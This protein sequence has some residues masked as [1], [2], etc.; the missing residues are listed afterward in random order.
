MLGEIKY[1]IRSIPPFTRYYLLIVTLT[2]IILSLSSIIG[3]NISSL[4]RL[5]WDKTFEI[6]R[7]ATTFLV[8]GRISLGFGFHIV[9]LHFTLKNLELK[10]RQEKTLDTFYMM[11]F[12]L[13]TIN[14]A[15]AF[16]FEHSYYLSHDL[17]MA[18]IYLDCQQDPEQLRSV[19]GFVI[20][21]KFK[22]I[23]LSYICAICFSAH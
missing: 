9:L 2:S 10:A 19:W 23:R 15:L 22:L 8:V 12:Y 20:K 6:W 5:N 7:L 16:I 14:I 21:C 4:F 13:C 1:R 11:I 3:F 17:A 18:L